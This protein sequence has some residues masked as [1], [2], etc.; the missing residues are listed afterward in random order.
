MKKLLIGIVAFFAIGYLILRFAFGITPPVPGT[1]FD[2]AGGMAAKLGCSARHITG[3]SPEQIKADL[4]SYSS[5]Y[6]LVSIRY[7]DEEDRVEANL[8]PGSTHSATFRK[9]LGCTLDIGDTS[10]LDQISLPLQQGPDTAANSAQLD[11]VLRQ[12]LADDNA[13]GLQT[14][15]LLVMHNGVIVGEA[16]AAGFDRN[17]PHLGWSMGKS[18]IGVLF[19]RME[20]EDRLN[21]SE[22][23][24]FAEWSDDRAEITLEDL[25]Q[26]TSG[27]K[28]GELYFPGS[29]ATRML[30]NSYS[31]AEVAI[32]QPAV[33]TPA[34]H[35]AYSSGTTNILS[36]VL[37]DKLGGSTEALYDYLYKTLLNPLGMHHT[38]VEPDPSGVFVGSSYVYASARDWG[39]LGNLLAADGQH[40][41]QTLLSP[42]WLA[43]AT[44]PN[45]STNEPRYGYQFWLNSAGS[46]SSSQPELRW[47]DLPTDA[48]AMRGNR[49]QI[50]TV[51][52]SRNAVFVRLG[53]TAGSYPSNKVFSSLL[54]KLDEQQ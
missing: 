23:K 24:L 50:V 2:V 30:F 45:S 44:T 36:R 19:G 3:L 5:A 28:F 13:A 38:Y 16:N 18:L 17:T 37:F 39:R 15:A 14:R 33:H 53:W 7:L 1:I 46:S 54:A 41:G 27:L 11:A 32:D 31:A 52:P 20:Y 43:R 26:M 42:D 48:F 40:N 47:P 10:A 21:T 25:L 6:G 34:T 49:A 9:G 8:S 29:D 51:I 35:W 12:Q 22:T 4:K